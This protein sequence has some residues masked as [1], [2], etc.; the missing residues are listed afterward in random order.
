MVLLPMMSHKATLEDK[1]KMRRLTTVFKKPTSTKWASEA[2]N[3]IEFDNTYKPT[4][5][6]KFNT[7]L[8]YLD[9]ADDSFPSTYQILA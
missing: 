4:L 3:Y 7:Y 9:D 6:Q 5:Y 8:E 1:N 2:K